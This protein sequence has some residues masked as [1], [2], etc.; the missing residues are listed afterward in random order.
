MPEP[1]LFVSHKHADSKIAQV[2]AGFL[3][4]KTNNGIRVYL[5]SNPT[6]KGPKIGKGLNAQLRQALWDTELLILVYTSADQDWQY[7]MWECGVATH[8]QSPDSTIIVFQCGSDIPAPFK[9]VI[10]VNVRNYDDIKRFI[11]QFFRDPELF[12]SLKG[13]LA[14]NLRDVQ[15]ENNARE[16]HKKIEEVLPII[17]DSQEEWT[18]WPFLKI[19]LPISE[20][21]R[22]ER[23][24]ETDRLALTQEIVKNF[25]EI[26]DS[27]P[28][29]AQLFG[30]AVF[31]ERLKFEIL[32]KTWKEKHPGLEASWFDSCC[33]Q[34]MIGS[35]RGFP[36]IRWTPMKEVEG[37]S[38]HTP[39]LCRIKTVTF[40]NIVHF[41]LYFFNLSDP[42]AIPVT[43]KMIPIGS[44][45]CKNLGEISPASLKLTDLREE[46]KIRKLNRIPILSEEGYP[47]Y[48]IHR[49]LIEQFIVNQIDSVTENVNPKSLTLDDLLNDK[50]M[51]ATFENTFVVVKRQATLAEAKSAMLAKPGC[52]DIFVTA[53]GNS[54]EAVQGWLT[55][56]DLVRSS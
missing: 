25:A 35:E 43:A 49:S 55:N 5:S 10:R 56:V 8:P 27:S 21:G 54:N 30:L 26:V 31:P 24:A 32:V 48:I 38:E 33:E 34:I 6:F 29:I 44:F 22:I 23:A 14:P 42:R 46:L 13:A 37:E 47:T 28:R 50:E 41:D 17:P 4:D 53:G 3:E 40:G 9:D 1:L 20:I 39:V 18:P 15:I 36:F 19:E 16:F 52:S 45:F 12:P 11:N 2:I 51:K 7:C